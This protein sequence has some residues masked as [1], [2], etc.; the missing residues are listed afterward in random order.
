MIARIDTSL[1]ATPQAARAP[2]AAASQDSFARVLR[3]ELSNAGGVRFSAHALQRL[4][5]RGIAVSDDQGKRLAGAVDQAAAKG[6]R[7][8]LVIMDR[9]A[10]VVNVPSR[11]VITAM[12]ADE[13]GAAVF[14][15]IDSAVVLPEAP[16]TSRKPE[17]QGLDPAW[18]SPLAADR[19]MRQNGME[20]Y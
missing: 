6:G 13:A 4:D 16:T 5:S 2:R 15:N 10:Y 11:T 19:P 9:V 7:E 3:A 8:S 20:V 14:T 18:G 1:L 12:P 17:V